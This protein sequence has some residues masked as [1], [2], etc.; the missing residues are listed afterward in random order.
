MTVVR[1]ACPGIHQ[2]WPRSSRVKTLGVTTFAGIPEERR[3]VRSVTSTST[4]S[5]TAK[6][7][8][9]EKYQREETQPFSTYLTSVKICKLALCSF[10]AISILIQVLYLTKICLFKAGRKVEKENY[11]PSFHMKNSQFPKAITLNSYDDV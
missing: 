2:D 4:T 6:F 5:T 7:Q 3:R 10:A 11:S 1:H 8:S 9:A